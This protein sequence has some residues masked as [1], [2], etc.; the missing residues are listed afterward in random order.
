MRWNSPWGVGFPGWH[1]ECS[2]MSTKYL[3][4]EFDIHGGGMD[5]QFPHHE[6]EI[7]QNIGACGCAPVR[8]WMHGNMLLLNGRKMSKSEG[9]YVLPHDLFHHSEQSQRCELTKAYSPMTLRFFFLQAHYRSTLNLTD[10]GLQSAEKGYQR[11][12]QAW[13]TLQKLGKGQGQEASVEDEFIL[14]Q[15]QAALE[16]MSDDF[17]TAEAIAALFQIVPK[18]NSLA[19]GKI[20]LSQVQESSLSELRKLWA[21]LLFDVFGLRQEQAEQQSGVVGDLMDLIL[22]LRK[23][24][25]VR[26]DWASSDKIRDHLAKANIQVKDNKDGQSTW[27]LK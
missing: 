20:A 16:A 15:I 5:L 18:I 22:D 23:E 17:N 8:Y 3:G 24:A 4:K 2:A 27:E 19:D 10:A 9:N 1:L 21:S 25:R 11:L 14:A 26:K 12:F 13:E 7:A 6:N